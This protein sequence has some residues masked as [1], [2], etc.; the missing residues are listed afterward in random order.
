MSNVLDPTKTTA[1]AELLPPWLTNEES[2]LRLQI[3]GGIGGNIVVQGRLSANSTWLNLTGT[4]FDNQ[5][6][7]SAGVLPLT[8]V[9]VTYD[10]AAFHSIR[11]ITTAI[12]TTPFTFG[13]ALFDY[14]NTSGNRV[15]VEPLAQLGTPRLITTSGTSASQALTTTGLRGVRLTARGAAVYFNFNNAASAA[16]HWLPLGASVEYRVPP[17]TVVHAI[18]DGAAGTL[19]ITE[20]I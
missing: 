7:F 15:T 9:M 1:N 2:I 6:S 11:I 14:G 12:I 20:I 3:E 10:I 16:S 5:S 18:Q 13:I 4:R 17:N 19:Q 8:G